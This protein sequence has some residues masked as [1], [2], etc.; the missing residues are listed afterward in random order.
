MWGGFGARRADTPFAQ[1]FVLLYALD[2]IMG[3]KERVLSYGRQS[4]ISGQG[5]LP[6]LWPPALLAVADTA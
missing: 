5:V 1:A 2:L 6:R 3:C 4:R